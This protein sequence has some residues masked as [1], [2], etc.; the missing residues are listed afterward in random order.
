M[1]NLTNIFKKKNMGQLVLASLFVLYLIMGFD[2]PELLANKIDTI[3]GKILVI[4]L[5]LSLFSFTNPILALLGLFV[6]FDLIKRSAITTGTA[7]IS[8]YVPSEQQKTYDINM[9][10]EAPYTLEE[11]IVKTMTP[12]VKFEG[13]SSTSSF[14]PVLDDNYDATPI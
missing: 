2:T 5:S 6:A 10:N 1:D 13:S 12:S 14:Q 9:Y 4:V 7:A 8:K 3:Y 11:E